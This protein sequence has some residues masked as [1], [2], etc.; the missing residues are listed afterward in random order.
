M[1]DKVL[2]LIEDQI[3][4]N[5]F[6]LDDQEAWMDYAHLPIK[7]KTNKRIV[8]PLYDHPHTDVENGQKETH[9]H[10]DTRYT[11]SVA[12]LGGT[13]VV[14]PLTKNQRLKYRFLKKKRTEEISKTPVEYIQKSK[15]KHK[16]I[17]KGKCPHRGYDL[18][19]EKPI[20]GIITCPL[21]SLKFSQITGKIFNY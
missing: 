4:T 12:V 15:L 17:H 20:N 9:Y 3:V 1:K 13:R 21:H 11:E 14:L 2:C 19:N 6:S 5:T 10:V 16:C 8:I 18:S 7:T